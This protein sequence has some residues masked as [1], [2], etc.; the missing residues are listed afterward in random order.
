MT[1][2]DLRFTQIVMDRSMPGY[3][4]IKRQDTIVLRLIL[5]LVGYFIFSLPYSQKRLEA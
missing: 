3:F 4:G 1:E 5:R 2:L